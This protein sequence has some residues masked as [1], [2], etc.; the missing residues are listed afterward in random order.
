MR[1]MALGWL[2]V[3]ALSGVVQPARAQQ[4]LAHV[5][6]VATDTLRDVAV[7]QREGGRSVIYYNPELIARVGPLLQE[8]FIA[9]EYGHVYYGHTGGAL[10]EPGSRDEQRRVRQE[11]EADCYAAVQLARSG[12]TS[13]EAAIKLFTRMGPFRHDKLHPTGS[14]RAAKILACLPPVDAASDSGE[15][16]AA[17]SADVTMIELT[18]MA[19][20]TLHG[21]VRVSI[22]GRPVGTLSTVGL[23]NPLRIRGLR[24]GE[25]R[26]ELVVQ[27]FTVDELLTINPSGSVRGGGIVM[28]ERG[29]PLEVTWAAD[30]APTLRP[31]TAPARME[32]APR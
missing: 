21:S 31:A 11:L 28:V 5:R 17:D 24:A 9:H 13:V 12:R 19:R 25:H 6:M 10:A 8:F 26:Y 2:A 18:D 1:S 22:D 7:T 4:A 14:Q 3:A 15:A 29:A 20:A 27:V 23:T 30:E 16:R 32:A